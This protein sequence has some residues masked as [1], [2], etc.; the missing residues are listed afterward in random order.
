MGNFDIIL[1]T[2]IAELQKLNFLI[3][4]TYYPGSIIYTSVPPK[5]NRQINTFW[6]IPNGKDK[7]AGQTRCRT[8]TKCI[9][10]VW[11]QE[12]ESGC[13]LQNCVIEMLLI[14]HHQHCI[15]HI[16]PAMPNY[17]TV[18]TNVVTARDNG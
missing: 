13:L 1:V 8:K 10:A 2:I 18:L 9:K 3:K 11:V 7:K 16:A 12:I 4:K 15:T 6:R 5:G 14:P 17:L